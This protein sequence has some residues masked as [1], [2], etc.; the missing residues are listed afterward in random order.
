MGEIIKSKSKSRRRNTK[1]KSRTSRSKSKSKRSYSR[2]KKNS[3]RSKKK[4]FNKSKYGECQQKKM[5]Q[6]M[7]EY[8]R[9]DLKQRNGKIIT[10]RKQAVAVGLSK[11]QREC[12]KSL[13]KS[14]LDK[15]TKKDI[16]RK[17]RN[18]GLKQSMTKKQMLAKIKKQGS[19]QKRRRN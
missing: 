11:S 7:G 13:N 6:V 19:K 12:G 1:N 15:L 14:S 9:G 16:L 4:A 8:S 10:D 3:K 5:K 17:F 2:S 18:S